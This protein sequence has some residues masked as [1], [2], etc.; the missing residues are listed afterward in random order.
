[1]I[2][3][4]RARSAHF[5]TI[6]RFAADPGEPIPDANELLGTQKRCQITLRLKKR[7]FEPQKASVQSIRSIW[8]ELEDSTARARVR[9]A[10]RLRRARP[11]WDVC[12][13]VTDYRDVRSVVTD[14]RGC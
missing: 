6:L 14:Y 2:V 5:Q 11:I 7:I 10:A 12:S 8:K 1:M 3:A 4:D 9:P 13:V